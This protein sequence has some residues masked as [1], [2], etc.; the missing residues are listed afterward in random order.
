MTKITVSARLNSPL[1]A[2]KLAMIAIHVESVLFIAAV[3]KHMH[4]SE[5]V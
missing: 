2:A 1:T 3:A 5:Q 4:I